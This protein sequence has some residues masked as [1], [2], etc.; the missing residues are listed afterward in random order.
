[1]TDPLQNNTKYLRKVNAK[2]KAKFIYSI[3]TK[4]AIMQVVTSGLFLQ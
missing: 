2:Y 4:E 1:M 3:S